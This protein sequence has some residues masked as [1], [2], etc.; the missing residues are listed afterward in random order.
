M[1]LGWPPWGL[2][3]HHWCCRCPKPFRRLVPRLCVSWYNCWWW[4]NHHPLVDEWIGWSVYSHFI[5]LYIYSTRAVVNKLLQ[6]YSKPFM[7]C[8]LNDWTYFMSFFRKACTP[9]KIWMILSR[10]SNFFLWYY[11]FL[12]DPAS[13]QLG[14]D[15]GYEK[16]DEGDQSIKNMTQV[17]KI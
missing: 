13:I 10:G 3:S 4:W 2:S 7:Y 11:M 15:H 8:M 17:W 12:S 9:Q 5:Y 14:P 1:G 6:Y 16:W